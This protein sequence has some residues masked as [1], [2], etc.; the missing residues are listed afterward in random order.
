MRYCRSEHLPRRRLKP[1]LLWL[2]QLCLQVWAWLSQPLT[3]GVLSV[4]GQVRWHD[5][6]CVAQFARQAS[7]VASAS[8]SLARLKFSLAEA[9]AHDSKTSRAI[10]SVRFIVTSGNQSSVAKC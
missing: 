6:L 4:V 10:A 5:A 9:E 7:D 1:Y 3:Q 8:R 2:W